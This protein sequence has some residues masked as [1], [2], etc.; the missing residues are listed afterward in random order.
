MAA[1][2]GKIK[3]SKMSLGV[4]HCHAFGIPSLFE[5]GRAPRAALPGV[6]GQRACKHPTIIQS[7]AGAHGLPCV[8]SN[9]QERNT[10]GEGPQAP[11]GVLS[12]IA[13]KQK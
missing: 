12:Q 7:L 4:P 8:R 11:S 13:C 1:K 3:Q 10:V 6:R 5:G 9:L 2:D